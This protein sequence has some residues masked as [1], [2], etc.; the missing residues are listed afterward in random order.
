M[1]FENEH[2][3]DDYCSISHSLIHRS[4]IIGLVYSY[5]NEILTAFI[6]I[7]TNTYTAR[8]ESIKTPVYYFILASN[9]QFN[10]VTT[11]IWIRTEIFEGI[12]S[13]THSF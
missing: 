8:N 12:Q 4:Q 1:K 9:I 7:V 11:K 6:Y 3:S 13:I 10:P 2:Q 5:F